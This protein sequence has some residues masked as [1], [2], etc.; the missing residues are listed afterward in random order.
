M[1][2]HE[3]LEFLP[4]KGPALTPAVQPFIHDASGLPDEPFKRSVIERH[5][6]VAQVTANL[7]TERVP[8]RQQTL[9]IADSARPV[10]DT[11]ERRTQAFAARFDFRDR[12]PVQR[13]APIKRE[14]EKI[15]SRTTVASSQRSRKRYPPGLLIIQ[16]ETES[17]QSLP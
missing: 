14:P 1:L 13:T 16:A 7:G 17:F 4:G 11:R 9:P 10:P 15:K 3:T 6:V 2:I 12:V 5:A 8:D